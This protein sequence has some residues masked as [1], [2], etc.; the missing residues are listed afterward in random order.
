M[1]RLQ[2]FRGAVRLRPTLTLPTQTGPGDALE[3]SGHLRQS[4]RVVAGLLPM[5]LPRPLCVVGRAA[6]TDAIRLG[7]REKRCL[8]LTGGPGEGKSTLACAVGAALWDE[9][10]YQQGVCELDMTGGRL[11]P[12]CAI[13][14]FIA[15]LTQ[16]HLV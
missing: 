10:A 15:R 16:D 11:A 14:V 13:G 1:R 7:L 3:I 5:Q 6:D 4:H 12:L 8:L 9:G 2:S